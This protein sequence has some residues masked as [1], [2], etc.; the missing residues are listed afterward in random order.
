MGKLN[1]KKQIIKYLVCSVALYT[2]K[3]WTLTQADR[4]KLI[5]FEM[6]ICRTVEKISWVDRQRRQMRKFSIWFRPIVKY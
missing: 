5:T 2:A 4:S 1:L 3:T 6:W